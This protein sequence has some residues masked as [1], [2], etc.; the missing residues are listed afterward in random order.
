MAS[1]R[2]FE[3]GT[4]GWRNRHLRMRSAAARERV[5]SGALVVQHI[6]GE[7]QVADI[8]TKSLGSSRIIALLKLANVTGSAWSH[9]VGTSSESRSVY[10][11]GSVFLVQEFQFEG[12][13]ESDWDCRSRGGS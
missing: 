2:A 10:A 11:S 9:C 8:G 3:P 7:F 1:I 12:S 4:G 6:S 5:D 13:E